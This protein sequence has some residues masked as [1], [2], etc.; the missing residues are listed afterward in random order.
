MTTNK[1]TENED[2]YFAREDAEARRKLALERAHKLAAAERDR[3]KQL[4]W[5][6]CPK[7]GMAL[8]THKFRE[9]QIEKCHHCGGVFLDDGELERLA[10][11][12]AGFVQRL[13]AVFK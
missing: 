3:L 12:E 7:C 9:V 11:K 4:H 5:M 13:V 2:E 8:E 1:P 10:G 6:H